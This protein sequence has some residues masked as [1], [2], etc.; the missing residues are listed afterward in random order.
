MNVCEICAGQPGWHIERWGDAA[1]SWA[2][3][4]HIAAVCHAM[5]REHERT[6]LY[7]WAV[8]AS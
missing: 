2:C 4:E 6:L 8:E 5:Q 7:M 1:V 3:N